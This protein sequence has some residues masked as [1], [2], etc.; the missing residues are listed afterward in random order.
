MRTLYICVCRDIRFSLREFGFRSTT[1]VP[2]FVD[3]NFADH[4]LSH[5]V[6]VGANTPAHKL[7]LLSG[8]S[9]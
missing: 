3:L 4:M 7:N 1:F 5:P 6:R 8:I 2:I 9:Y